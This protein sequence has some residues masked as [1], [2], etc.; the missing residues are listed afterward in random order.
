VVSQ[1]TVV[2][3]LPNKHEIKHKLILDLLHG[4]FENEASV[5]RE[6]EVLGMDLTQPRQVLVIGAG[7][8]IFRKG[9]GSTEPSEE[10]MAR[11]SQIVIGAV[12]DFFE[13]P[14]DIICAYI[15]EGD[16][17]LLK[18]SN[19]K[20]MERWAASDPVEPDATFNPS[21][22]NLEAV[23]RAASA[24]LVYL[25]SVTHASLSIGIGRYHPGLRGLAS[26][27]EDAQAALKLG[28][29]I[30]GANRVHCL[31]GLGTASF[32]GVS[33]EKT[34]VDL[35]TFLLGPLEQEPDLIQTL[36][37]FFEHDCS[38]SVTAAA[39]NVHRNTLAYRLE[40]IASLIGLDPRK[41][42][43]A[44]QIRLALILRSFEQQA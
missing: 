31:D 22:A 9:R 15:G 16:V 44:V 4:D 26:S 38:P 19:R 35:A 41:F 6:A 18:A 33:D 12:V 37:S 36:H 5:L 20:N 42:E 21:W 7:E 14:S 30:I 32:V 39:L 40:K 23:K 10:E 34:K 25:R 13:L 2:D 17:A 43:E 27:Y 24:L 29:R 28:R 11:R 1:T 8:Y 3:R